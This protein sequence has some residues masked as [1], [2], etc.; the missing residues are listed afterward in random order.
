MSRG[1]DAVP[2]LF[3]DRD[4]TINVDHVYI[5]D[6]EKIELIPGAGEA[7]AKANQAGYRIVVVTNQSG[8]GRGIF[9]PAVLPLLHQRLDQLLAKF[10]AKIDRYAVCPHAPEESC[11][12]RKPKTK[13]IEDAIRFDEIDHTRSWMVGDSIVD[14][15]AGAAANLSTA[16]VLT[17]K[18]RETQAQIEPGKAYAKIVAR[19][20]GE[21]IS[22]ILGK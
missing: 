16:L 15:G 21:A 8:I 11:A 1:A 20:L 10:G 12:C 14:L 18:G 5:G 6:P 19:D 13:L 3:L 22:A 4:G 7:I 17:G 2:A 9:A